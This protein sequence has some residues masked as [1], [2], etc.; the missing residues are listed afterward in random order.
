VHKRQFIKAGFLGFASITGV[1]ALLKSIHTRS[2]A[3]TI[4]AYPDPILRRVAGPVNFAKDEIITLAHKMIGIL[5]T[6]APID[7]FL[8][9]SLSKGLSAPQIGIQKRLMVCGLH[10]ALKVLVNPE[11]LTKKGTY[12]NSEYCLSLP[13]YPTRIVQRSAY[14][15]VRY[16][17]LQNKEEVLVAR[18][19]A[20]G[21]IEHEMDHLNGVLYID[22]LN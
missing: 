2:T 9:G 8:K 4:V 6:R 5:R 10:G 18:N 11:I 1:L 14:V 7:F 12:E 13:E 20:A 16:R 17:N 22:Y 15:K 3:L 21:L 19:H